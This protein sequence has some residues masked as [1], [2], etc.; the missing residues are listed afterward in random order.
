V[1]GAETSQELAELVNHKGVKNLVDAISGLKTRLVH[2]STDYVFS[3]ETYRPYKEDDAPCPTSYYGETKLRGEQAILDGTRDGVIIRTSWLYYLKGINFVRKILTL[4]KKRSDAEPDR[5]KTQGE[6]LEVVADQ[7]GSPTFAEDLANFVVFRILRNEF[8]SESP[9]IYHYTNSG[10]A[11][12]YDLAAATL[13]FHNA[14]A[15]SFSFKQEINCKINP[16]TTANFPTAAKR[17]PYSVL[18]LE[19]IRQDFGVIPPHWME[20]L[21]GLVWFDLK[22]LLLP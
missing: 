16:T 15:R 7:I 12:W 20:S 18:S 21:R 10:I 14:D 1:D 5:Y 3:G 22:V 11:S 6:P 17:P 8:S 19:K 2:I 9:E 13:D 4:A